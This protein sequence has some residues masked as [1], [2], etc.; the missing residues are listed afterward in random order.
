MLFAVLLITLVVNTVLVKF[1]PGFEIAILVLHIVGFF[2]ILIPVVHLAPKSSN[3]F[4]WTEFTN[5][6][7]YPSAGTYADGCYYL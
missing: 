6:S 5:Y 2:A 1:L 4:V 3:A 7:G